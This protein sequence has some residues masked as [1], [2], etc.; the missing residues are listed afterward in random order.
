MEDRKTGTSR[1]LKDW[2]GMIAHTANVSFF[3]AI[4]ARAGGEQPAQPGDARRRTEEEE[5]FSNSPPLPIG[6]EI[7]AY[8]PMD[9]MFGYATTIRTLA[10]DR[11]SFTMQFERYEAV[12]CAIAEEIPPSPDE[13]P[14]LSPIEGPALSPAEGTIAA[15][16]KAANKE[17]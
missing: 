16:K 9:Q 15:W 14:A 1:L 7:T 17:E 2:A 6:P 5:D 10:Q 11:A 4:I 12:P 3:K 8:V 13:E